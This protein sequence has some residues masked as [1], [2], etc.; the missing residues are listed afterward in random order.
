LCDKC[1][2]TKSIYRYTN[3]FS[4]IVPSILC[5]NKTASGC[6]SH[7]FFAKQFNFIKRSLVLLV[8][9]WAACWSTKQA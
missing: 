4:T 5:N 7:G 8:N 3:I 6:A 9:S 1:V 2:I